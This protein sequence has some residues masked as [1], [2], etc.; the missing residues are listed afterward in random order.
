MKI[1]LVSV[2]ESIE[3]I[4]NDLLVTVQHASGEG[5][6]FVR[7]AQFGCANDAAGTLH[8]GQKVRVTVEVLNT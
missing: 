4:N 7:R 1:E 2:I 3:R 6:Q 8:V 5:P